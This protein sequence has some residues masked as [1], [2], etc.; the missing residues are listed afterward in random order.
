MMMCFSLMK[1]NDDNGS[2]IQERGDF[3]YKPKNRD[4]GKLQLVM[5]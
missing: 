4:K 2:E 1:G 3:M 5:S